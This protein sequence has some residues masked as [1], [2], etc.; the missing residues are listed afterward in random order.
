MC[1]IL[2]LIIPS[3]I[4]GTCLQ[5]MRE[6][7]K[8]KYFR[9]ILNIKRKYMRSWPKSWPWIKHHT[10]GWPKN[11]RYMRAISYP[12]WT[13]TVSLF[14]QQLIPQTKHI[15]LGQRMRSSVWMSIC[16]TALHR[17]GLTSADLNW[18]NTLIL[19]RYMTNCWTISLRCWTATQSFKKNSSNICF[20]RMWSMEI[21]YA[22]FF[23][24]RALSTFRWR[25]RQHCLTEDWVHINSWWTEL[26]QLI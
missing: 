25:M 24:N 15:L 1:I 2:C 22:G 8:K 11:I 13:K 9:H 17:T 19:P 23:V 4:S 18:V 7:P 10:I 5:N 3:L 6:V 20:Y 12:Y 21:R 26:K 14:L 16:I